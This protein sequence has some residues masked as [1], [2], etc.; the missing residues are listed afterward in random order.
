MSETVVQVTSRAK[1]IDWMKNT[2]VPN[3]YPLT[4]ARN[5]TLS[6]RD[7]KYFTDLANVPVG[8]ARLRQVRMSKGRK[9]CSLLFPFLYVGMIIL[10]LNTCKIVM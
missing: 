1:W 2:F 9:Y 3:Y 5:H 7:Q 4:D 6:V 10:E 8:P